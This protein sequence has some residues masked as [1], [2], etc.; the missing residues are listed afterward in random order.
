MTNSLLL[1]ATSLHCFASVVPRLSGAQVSFAF[2]E[3]AMAQDAV[4]ALQQA[5]GKLKPRGEMMVRHGETL[6]AAMNHG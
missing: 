3:V 1:I 2:R 6:I 4:L 5:Q